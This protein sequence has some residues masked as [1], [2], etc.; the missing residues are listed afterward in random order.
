M[1]SANQL[2]A[3]AR[4]IRDQLANKAVGANRGL[5]EAVTAMAMYT[6]MTETTTRQLAL[7]DACIGRIRARMCTHGLPINLP[8]PPSNE[9]VSESDV[10]GVVV[11]G[12]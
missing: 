8:P 9:A 3:N 5:V 7:A 12:Q 11:Q 1:S 2:L 4:L 10:N 6:E